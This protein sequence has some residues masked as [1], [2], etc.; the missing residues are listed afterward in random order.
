MVM[1]IEKMTE[2][3]LLNK[4]AALEK[5]RERT[6]KALQEYKE[7][8]ERRKQEVPLG[9]PF[10]AEKGENFWYINPGTGV[11]L[12][13]NTWIDTHQ[14]LE[15]NL[16]MFRSQDS[17]HKH[18]EML[19]EWRKALVANAKGEPIDIK[20]LLPLLPKGW[21]AMEEDGNW[22]WFCFMNKK[23][24]IRNGHWMACD[25]ENIDAFNLK[26]AEDWENSLME[27]GL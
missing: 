4:I 13:T 15:R 5:E 24:E 14:E 7:E 6:A 22:C 23:P 10:I 9:V 18:A 12:T 19:L 3:K 27:C 26:P 20:V 11:C 8:L 17:V 21:V 2:E 25:W 16:N 1:N